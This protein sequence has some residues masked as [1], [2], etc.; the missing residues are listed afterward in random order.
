VCDRAPGTAGIPPALDLR[1]NCGRDARAPRLDDDPFELRHREKKP[2]LIE[3]KPRRKEDSLYSRKNHASERAPVA[4]FVSRNVPRLTE[5]TM[6]AAEILRVEAELAERFLDQMRTRTEQREVVDA[7]DDLEA[8]VDEPQR[9]RER[10]AVH[11]FEM[12]RPR[13]G[14]GDSV[15]DRR[16]D[17]RRNATHMPHR[18]RKVE[19][20]RTD[21]R[22]DPKRPFCIEARDELRLQPAQSQR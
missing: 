3:Q 4:L 12:D 21:Q 19:D 14:D 7:D 6:A 9:A 18:L 8:V 1:E 16:L 11:S 20:S 17:L 10:H 15:A 22:H 5:T 2:M 13:S